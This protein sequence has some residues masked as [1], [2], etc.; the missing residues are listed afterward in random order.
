MRLALILF[1]VEPIMMLI[2]VFSYDSSITKKYY[3]FFIYLDVLVHHF[4]TPESINDF[5][6]QWYH[7][8]FTNLLFFPACRK[9][10]PDLFCLRKLGN[11]PQ[12]LQVLVLSIWLSVY[13]SIFNFASKIEINFRLQF[14]KL[15]RFIF[16]KL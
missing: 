1:Y 2:P 10:I 13:C 14:Q 15:P 12:V 7:L 3:F 8:C 4:Y 16:K 5:H 9:K 6:V 11:T